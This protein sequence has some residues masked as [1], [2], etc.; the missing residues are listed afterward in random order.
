M[1]LKTKKILQ[2]YSLLSRSWLLL[3]AVT[4]AVGSFFF[5]HISPFELND[6]LFSD[7]GDALKNYFTY[8]YYVAHNVSYIEFEAMNYPFGE[9]FMYT[10]CHPLLAAILKF[11]NAYFP[12]ISRHSIGI[13]NGLLLSSNAI[14]AAV[15]YCIFKKLQ[16]TDFVAFVAAI[17]L[18]FLNPQWARLGGHLALSYSFAL[19]VVIYALL[20]FR[21]ENRVKVSTSLF[22]FNLFLFFTHAYL[23]MIAVSLQ[24]LFVTIRIVEKYKIEQLKPRLYHYFLLAASVLPLII[25]Y[26]FIKLTDHH[27]GRTTNPWGFFDFTSGVKEI[28]F[29]EV[30]SFLQSVITSPI[31][32]EGKAFIGT[33]SVVVFFAFATGSLLYCFRFKTFKWHPAYLPDA[34][35]Q[36]MLI[37][38]VVLLF[39]SFGFPFVG[40]LKV[41]L[42]YFPILKQFRAVGRFAWIFYWV[43]SIG[44][45]V[46]V[47]QVNLYLKNKGNVITANTLLIAFLGLQFFQAV[48]FQ[49]SNRESM[50]FG[51][52]IFLAQNLEEQLKHALSTVDT[53]YTAILPLPF[54]YIGSENFG[55]PGEDYMYWISDVVSYHTQ[56]PQLSA[57]LTRTGIGESKQIMQLFTSP[58][59]EKELQQFNKKGVN[60]LVI[61]NNQTLNTQEEQWLNEA[62]LIYHSTAFS[63]YKLPAMALFK[64]TANQHFKTFQILEPVLIP[65]NGFLVSADTLDWLRVDFNDLASALVHDGAGAFSGNM[66]D[67]SS[68]LSIAPN[69]LKPA[70]YFCSFWMYNNGENF[71][72]DAINSMV[73]MQEQDEFGTMK[74]LEP[75]VNPAYSMEI[76]GDWSQVKLSFEAKPNCSYELIVKGSDLSKKIIYCDDVLVYDKKMSIYNVIVNNGDSI[77][78]EN[79]SWI[80]MK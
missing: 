35:L 80:R 53:S 36:T 32:W 14:T 7:S 2:E 54:Y 40:K 5:Y 1:N 41:L 71:G 18:T 29:N 67:Y 45:V 13:L 49:V 9:H 79:N 19:P 8:Q 15:V 64:N 72:Q 69:Q 20:I 43:W 22:F 55:K 78:F 23:G 57:Y 17:C 59:Y 75:V 4:A 10:D 37:A 61:Y 28:I 42:D 11:L 73:F 16:L 33:A 70:E 12:F 25:F 34:K 27:A 6:F 24:L 44:A 31:L 26:G 38:A 51:H 58:F 63:F 76:D 30:S 56:L 46:V 65:L 39:F 3:T 68:L 48:S 60:F 74:W 52:N 66:K 47:Y 62:E 21:D 77:L 50:K